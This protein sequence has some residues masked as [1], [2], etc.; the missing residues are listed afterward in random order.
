MGVRV[1]WRPSPLTTVA[2]TLAFALV[3]NVA[4]GTVEVSSGVGKAVVWMTVGLLALASLV[5]EIARVR[6]G[7]S[8][9][10]ADLEVAAG[11]LAQSVRIRLRR[12]EEHRKVTDPI[13]LPVRWK[14]A[15][16]SLI[17]HWTNICGAALGRTAVPVALTGELD[18]I[19]AVY[20]RIPSGRL[21]ILGAAGSGKTVLAARLAAELVTLREPGGPVPYLVSIASWNPAESL[22]DWLT[23]QLLRDHPGTA[24]AYPGYPNLAAALFR[25]VWRASA[26]ASDDHPRLSSRRLRPWLAQ[27]QISCNEP[28]ISGEPGRPAC[29]RS[30]SSSTVRAESIW[31]STVRSPRSLLSP[32]PASRSARRWPGFRRTP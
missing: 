16:D 30:S 21:V 23:G 28:S 3:G 22:R 17:D 8:P 27:E 29:H 5:L 12:E 4:T 9:E 24:G 7:Q 19:S 15:D 11:G 20:R 10:A 18:E 26:A 1:R 32:A 13:P 2:V 14:P 31:P 6:T 25:E